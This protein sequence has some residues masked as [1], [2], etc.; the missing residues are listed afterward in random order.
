[1]CRVLAY[2]GE[3]IL[4]E[5][6]LYRPD[7]SFVNQTHHAALLQRLN[8]AGCGMLAW[9]ARSEAPEVPYVYRTTQLAIY[10]RNLRALSRKIR[11]TALLAHLRGVAYSSRSVIGDQNLHPFLFEGGTLALAHNGQ[12]ARF[13]ELKY[14][15][16]PHMKPE[17]VQRVR[18]TTDSEW[19]YAL[20]LS[21][22][23][24]PSADMSASEIV[25]GVERALRVIARVRRE[26]G[27]RSFSPMNL[28]LCDGNDLVAVCFTFDLDR[29]EPDTQALSLRAP[30][31]TDFHPLDE[32]ALRIWYTTGHSYGQ[33]EGEWRMQ[34][35]GGEATSCIVAS[36]PLT[37]DRSTWTAVPLQHLVYV[38]RGADRAPSVEVVPLDIP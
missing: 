17:L 18:G 27:I 25:G 20:L 3:P 24:D 4:L 8:L 9:D 6:L 19:F 1:M 30:G 33:Y 31:P 11:A 7:M 35:A 2:L 23:E 16:L 28:F 14:A 10:D 37:Q 12:L 29:Y 21:Q 5:D 34:N 13:E 15:L 38:R 22:L 36:E 32:M 26:L